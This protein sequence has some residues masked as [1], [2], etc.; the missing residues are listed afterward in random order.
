MDYQYIDVKD[1]LVHL[2]EQALIKENIKNIKVQK[3]DPREAADIPC[4][5]INRAGDNET[6]RVI[7]DD[8]GEDYDDTISTDRIYEGTSFEE[9]ME[10][11]VW[12]TNASERDRLYIFIKVLLF[13]LR[14]VLT[15]LGLRNITL[16]GG[17]DEQDNTFPPVPMYWGAITINYVI[18][19]ILE[20]QAETD[21]GIMESIDDNIVNL[22]TK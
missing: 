1:T 17:H 20:D 3:S 10:V 22:Y 6:D 4:I 15:G 14:K 21:F 13:S 7:G 12:H 18:D 9:A 11:R 2:I 19:L 5:C 16:K 8:F